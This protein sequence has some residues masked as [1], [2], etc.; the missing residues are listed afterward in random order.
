LTRGRQFFTRPKT[1]MTDGNDV[2]GSAALRQAG[3]MTYNS[4]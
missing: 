3:Y 2:T 1:S 4:S